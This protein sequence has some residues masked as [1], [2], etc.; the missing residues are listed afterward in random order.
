VIETLTNILIPPTP[1]TPHYG[2]FWGE[3]NITSSISSAQKELRY[4]FEVWHVTI[5]IRKN[6]DTPPHPPYDISS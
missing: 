1:F 3:L 2:I 6:C 4:D 5:K